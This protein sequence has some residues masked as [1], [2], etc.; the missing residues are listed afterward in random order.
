MNRRQ[1]VVAG[2]LAAAG[3]AGFVLA[4]QYAGATL[5]ARVEHLPQSVVGIFTLHDY[6][7]AY[8]HVPAVK[9][10]LAACS[11]VSIVVPVA[12]IAIACAVMF[13][14]PKR[15]LHGSARFARDFEIRKS[16]LLNADNGKPAILIGKYKGRYLTFPGQQFVMLA[17]PTRSGKGVAVAIP[18]LLTFPDSM[19]VLDL[20]LENYSYTSGYR[21]KYGQAIYLWAPFSKDGRTHR[22]NVFD[23]VATKAEHERIDEVES[24]ARKFYPDTGSDGGDWNGAARDLFMGL[25]LF[26]METATPGRRCTF[27]EILR[28]SSGMGKPVK[29][30]IESLRRTHGLSLTCTSALDRFLSN[31][32]K[33]LTSIL[34]TFNARMG[35]FSNPVVDSATSCSD[36]DVND[37]RRQR[38]TIYVGI[39]PNRLE[40]AALLANLFFSQ[41]IDVNTEVLPE[42]DRTLRHQCLLMLDEFTAMGRIGIINKANS[43]IAG[44]NLRLL[45][46]IQATAQMEPQELYGKEGARTLMVNHAAK[47]VYPPTD[48]EEA[49]TVSETLGYFTE[50]SVSK[51]RT[52]GKSSSS[53]ENKSDQRRALMLPQELAEMPKNQEIIL[54]F[55]KPILCEKAYFYNDNLFLDRLREISPTLDAIRKRVPTEQE[56]KD[57]AGSGELATWDEVPRED[58]AAWMARRDAA[59]APRNPDGTKVMRA[60]E[61]LAMDEEE[62][63]PE[64]ADMIR[65]AL[66]SDLPELN[67]KGDLAELVS[68]LCIGVPEE[69]TETAQTTS[70]VV[71]G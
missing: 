40:S 9:K 43:F 25:A 38:M 54:G 4:G 42:H 52:R 32:E 13:A 30:H 15:E 66:F 12:P 57:V 39:Q 2:A 20:K 64:L 65:H 18:N 49:K 26:L 62:I 34:F 27:G 71:N 60:S 33:V 11:L 70:E 63:S 10:A 19:V 53:G 51:S 29:E 1:K 59:A 21:R 56:L 31:H 67:V 45:T 23:A 28:Q 7:Q 44:Y 24:I 58:I 36:F 37:V 46:I 3:I 8:G 14:K 55:G 50:T 68:L 61:L 5:F 47:I 17:A 16:G 35:I 22:W 48:P 41:L 69:T 6:W